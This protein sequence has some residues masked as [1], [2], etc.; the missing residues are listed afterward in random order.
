M[1][2]IGPVEPG[3]DVLLG[4]LTSGPASDELA[5]EDTALEM[6]RAIKR[7][8][9]V[10]SA[11]RVPGSIAR[12][13][14][15]R[16]RWLA[17]AGTVATAAALTAAAYTQAL[18]APLQ[19]VAYHVLGFVGVPRAHHVGRARG[20][21][22]PARS[23]RPRPHSGSQ[24]GGAPPAPVA[25][26]TP[27]PRPA[28]EAF[29]P[30][31]A[32]LSIAVAGHLIVAGQGDVLVG[33]L[34]AQGNAVPGA[35]LWLVERMTGWGA[36]HVAGQA[37]TG[38]HGRAV[39]IVRDLTRNAVF[40]FR[41][42]H[43]ALS[44]PVQVIVVPSVFVRLVPGPGGKAE[45]VAAGSPLAAPGDD[46][47]LQVRLGGRWVTVQTRELSPDNRVR[48]VV[49]V[50]AV[51]RAYRVVLVATSAHGR[52]VSNPVI[53]SPRSGAPLRPASQALG[54]RVVGEPLS[55]SAHHLK[56]RYTHVTNH[57]YLVMSLFAGEHKAMSL[58]ESYGASVVC[59]HI[60][61]DIMIL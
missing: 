50:A 58:V 33:R 11:P 9:I 19:N 59:G 60:E 6:Y 36:W 15:R 31:P 25:P 46:V 61:V 21:A 16:R 38:P 34:T 39:V 27:R 12:R 24:A 4:L 2:S 51:P 13:Q 41:G 42:P 30:G 54:V 49:Q 20:G 26:A 10:T 7:P 5:G 35:R 37:T 18:P 44:R 48:F 32:S 43:G 55:A 8:A 14:A 1:D 45:T 22:H 56:F 57:C 53:V 40:R 3:L 29:A 52:S 47:I 23:V 28:R 17:A